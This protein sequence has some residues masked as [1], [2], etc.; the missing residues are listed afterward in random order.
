MAGFGW[1]Y[2]LELKTAEEHGALLGAIGWTWDFRNDGMKLDF[3]GLVG[4]GK[5]YICDFGMMA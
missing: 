5:P 3:S 2:S 4:Y 1:L